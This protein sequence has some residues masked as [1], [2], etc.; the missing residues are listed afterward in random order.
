M[1]ER[2]GHTVQPKGRAKTKPHS[3]DAVVLAGGINEVPLYEG[4]K[5]GYKALVEFGGQPA[6]RHVLEALRG[7][8]HIRDI[9]VVGDRAK[10]RKAIGDIEVTFT[11]PGDSLLSSAVAGLRA[12]ADRELVLG[13]AADLPL[14]TSACIDG[15]VEAAARTHSPYPSSLWLA[16][17]PQDAFEGPFAA[18]R[19]GHNRF[20]DITVCHGNAWLVQPSCLE[21]AAAQERLN[22]MYA[23]RKSPIRSA[24]ALGVDVGLAYVIGVHFL[25]VLTLNQMAKVASRQFK[26]GIVPVLVP[27]PELAMDVDE[28]EDYELVQSIFATRPAPKKRAPSKP[29][30]AAVKAKGLAPLEVGVFTSSLAIPDPIEALDTV[31]KL[32]IRVVQLGPM[33]SKWYWKPGQAK[34]RAAL[35]RNGLTA[36]AACAAFDGEDYSDIQAVR[37]T[38]GY[39]PASTMKERL[40]RTRKVADL[41]A[42]VGARFVTTHIGFM[43][44]DPDSDDYQRL[45]G[46]VREIADYCAER[47]LVFALETGQETAEELDAFI[48]ATG[49]DNVKVNFDPANMIMYGTGEPLPALDVIGKHVVHVHAKDG[50]WPEAEGQ[51]GHEEPL[52]KG[53]V[54]LPAFVAKLK[55]IGYTGPLVIERE[56][57]EDRIGDI[58][59]AKRLL[60]KL[61]KQLLQG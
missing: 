59:R 26:V 14:V 50:V 32:G 19:K 18:S 38:V 24:L 60:Q 51:L 39:L 10:L 27:T 1:T 7:S 58:R 20:K 13:I 53:A 25:H 37:E 47:G 28:P 36:T 22:A 44:P 42:A 17:V 54:D 55:Q 35:K 41:A 8:K 11:E 46:A 5:P 3:V 61:T 49:R 12:F 30:K 48:R 15:F 40:A 57:G 6:V 29:K 52:G 31:R 45:L 2:A 34:L 16:A 9:C 4:Y 56:A 21:N 33:E 43:P 23:A